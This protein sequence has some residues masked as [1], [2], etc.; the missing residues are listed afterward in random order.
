MDIMSDP[1][2]P[3]RGG[4]RQRA[5][6]RARSRTPV[7]GTGAPRPRLVAPPRRGGMRQRVL[8]RPASSSSGP[9]SAPLG[10]GVE[11]PVQNDFRSHVARLFLLNDFSAKGAHELYGAA[12][13]DGARNVGDLA[14]A[15]A[16]GHAPGNIHRDLMRN[17]AKDSSMPMPY[18]AAIPLQDSPDKPVEQ[19]HI[20][21]LLPHE[22]LEGFARRGEFFNA[23]PKNMPELAAIR[24]KV[25]TVLSAPPQELTPIGVHGDGVPHQKKGTIECLSWNPCAHPHCERIRFGVLEKHY[26]CA[27]GCKGQHRK[28]H[29][30]E[31][32][33]AG[34]HP[35]RHPRP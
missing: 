21:L 1:R 18:W 33:L 31:Q 27:Y 16:S 35:P 4:M 23:I 8:P 28:D 5:F 19:V 17:L 12:Q 14:A 2:G 20:P 22:V 25:A 32:D 30:A 3:P 13:R 26:L 9:G 7:P 10:A 11:P 6:A 29:G 24:A 34:A 15:G